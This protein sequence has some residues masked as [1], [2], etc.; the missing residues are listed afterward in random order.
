MPVLGRSLPAAGTCH[1]R[2]RMTVKLLALYGQPADPVSWDQRYTEEHLPLAAAMPGLRAQRAARV[3][4]TA[5]GS[6]SPYYLIGE[7]FF[8]DVEAMQT[9]ASSP[10]GEAAATNFAELAPPGSLLLVV[11]E[12]LDR[13]F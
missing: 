13:T 12:T 10:E 9:G 6:A 4:G 3:H 5:D 11:E 7:L 8:D 1:Y 2:H